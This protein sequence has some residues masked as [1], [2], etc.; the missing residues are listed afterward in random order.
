M[1]NFLKKMRSELL[2]EKLK[3]EAEQSNTQNRID[4]NEKFLQKLREEE[5]L[6]YDVFSPRRKN[7]KLQE[8]IHLLE[9]E[10][11]E[12]IQNSEEAEQNLFQLDARLNELDGVLKGFRKQESAAV[13]EPAKV[14]NTD[15][16]ELYLFL[17]RNIR[18][19]LQKT[20]LCTKLLQVDPNRCLLELSVVR[21]TLVKV[22]ELLETMDRFGQNEEASDGGG[23]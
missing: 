15:Q 18:G 1:V 6:T 2:E 16:D 9:E 14:K 13:K 19:L 17:Q 8:H 22:Q 4:R 5:D 7:R 12:L 10:Q 23:N 21:N 20:E 3:L 11:K